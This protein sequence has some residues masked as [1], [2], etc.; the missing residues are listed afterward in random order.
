MKNLHSEIFG[1]QV[2]KYS[3]SSVLLSPTIEEMI[4]KLWEM[5]IIVRRYSKSREAEI[6]FQKIEE[7]IFWAE[8]NMERNGGL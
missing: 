1:E 8:K 3:K 6:C 5:S 7:A 4:G 2:I